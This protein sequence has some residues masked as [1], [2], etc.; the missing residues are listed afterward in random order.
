MSGPTRPAEGEG[1]FGVERIAAGTGGKAVRLAEVVRLLMAREQTVRAD[2]VERCLLPVLDRKVPRLYWL[3]GGG[4]AQPL[5]NTEWFATRTGAPRHVGR[6]VYSAGLD[7]PSQPRA[8]SM[9][10]SLGQ[11][12]AGAAEWLRRVWAD[13]Q[14]E[15]SILDDKQAWAVYLAVSEADARACWGWVPAGEVTQE[16]APSGQAMSDPEAAEQW[17]GERLKKRRDELKTSGPRHMKRLSE[18]SGLGDRKI[19]HLITAH[20]A[21]SNA[22]MWQGLQKKG[23]NVTP[24]GGS[25]ESAGAGAGGKRGP[26]PGKGN[27][28]Q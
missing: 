2:A 12:A 3:Q 17:T 19:R 21:E 8:S 6:R 11:G 4:F 15:D 9:A 1:V 20:E 10:K 16:A 13:P 7:R 23:D 5:A 24:I 25:R 28:A 27:V 18:E 14:N 22:P 26:A